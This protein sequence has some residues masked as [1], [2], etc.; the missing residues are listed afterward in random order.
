MPGRVEF[1]T[2]SDWLECEKHRPALYMLWTAGPAMPPE[3]IP[4]P[5]YSVL[6]V[7][8]ERIDGALPVV[9]L[10]GVLSDA[11]WA[12]F[13]DQV[14]PDGLFIAQQSGSKEAVGTISAVHNPAATRFYFPGG[15]EIGYFVVAQ[16]HRNRG[17]G[18]ALLTSA[19]RRLLQGGYRHF[20]V[21]VQGWRLPAIRCYLQAGFQPFLHSPGLQD[22]WKS[23]FTALDRQSTPHAWPTTL[24]VPPI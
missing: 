9:E 6:P 21:G 23:I 7:R 15:G 14:V 24:P 10:D 11:Q 3:P 16:D 5:G 8:S 2:S 12:S 4:P 17:L 19:V 1:T 13:R 22:R 18:R 20:F